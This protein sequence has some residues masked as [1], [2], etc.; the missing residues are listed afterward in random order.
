MCCC[1]SGEYWQDALIKAFHIDTYVGFLQLSGGKTA[2]FSAQ[3]IC[4]ILFVA[5]IKVPRGGIV[6]ATNIILRIKK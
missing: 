2:N 5:Q 6:C 1:G 3:C 4:M